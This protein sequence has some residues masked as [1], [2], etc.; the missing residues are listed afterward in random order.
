MDE[1]KEPAV[2][3]VRIREN[4]QKI[5][6]VALI[7]VLAVALILLLNRSRPPNLAYMGA[8]AEA[9]LGGAGL[10]LGITA[11]AY[12]TGMGIGFGLG[13]LRTVRSRVL[14]LVSTACVESIRGTPLLVQI[15]VLFAVMSFY[16]P[17]NLPASARLLLTGFLALMINTSA[18]QAEIFRAGLQSVAVGQV[19]A[20]KAV[21]LSY[22]G[23]MR[24][25]ILPQAIRL[26]VPPLTNE[27][28][29]LL[30]GSALLFVLGVHELTYEGR[31]LSFT[32]GNF[33]EVYT[34]MT[35]MYLAMTVPIAKGVAHLER[36]YRIPGLGLQVE[37]STKRTRRTRT[38]STRALGLDLSGRHRGRTPRPARTSGA[39]ELS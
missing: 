38:A 21:G 33:L 29:L 2:W 20:A 6:A 35:V 16:N 31:L 25:V 7:G 10:T 14:R 19:E 28:I 24:T 18:Y 37:P 8:A 27:F 22:W 3:L 30:K 4:G 36:R 12:A 5:A 1:E 13:W 9:L 11:V 26:V 15:F 23:S 34:V 39:P 32:S 17:G